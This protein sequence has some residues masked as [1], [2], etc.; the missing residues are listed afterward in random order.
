METYVRIPYY[1]SAPF[2]S[3]LYLTSDY[4]RC[5][6]VYRP[7]LRFAALCFLIAFLCLNEPLMNSKHNNLCCDFT[8]QL[9]NSQIT[10]RQRNSQTNINFERGSSESWKHDICYCN[11]C[12]LAVFEGFQCLLHIFFLPQSKAVMGKHH[13]RCDFLHET[14]K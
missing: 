1:Q 14:T 11:C 7:A 2:L 6:I 10:I 13:W 5:A 3:S 12:N 8:E 9:C 4:F